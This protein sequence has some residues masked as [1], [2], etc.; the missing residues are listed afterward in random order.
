MK[1]Q[2]YSGR[3]NPGSLVK[4]L[5]RVGAK[6]LLY[7][8]TVI[9]ET[10]AY[11]GI[12]VPQNVPIIAQAGSAGTGI[13]KND[14]HDGRTGDRIRVKKVDFHLN[15]TCAN[16]PDT[17][18]A[19]KAFRLILL[20]DRNHNGGPNPP[21]QTDVFNFNASQEWLWPN[22]GNRHRFKQLKTLTFSVTNPYDS[23]G[24]G[25]LASA[26]KTLEM[27]CEMDLPIDYKYDS[28]DGDMENITDNNLYLWIQPI[29]PDSP[30]ALSTWYLQGSCRFYYTS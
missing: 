11:Y 17:A 3:Q 13:L 22:M 25:A 14:N 27:S 24:T 28:T 1:R 16:G 9:N 15:M 6:T 20:L 5:P 23:S 19:T 12:G 4:D 26:N 30:A 8:D 10:A 7:A 2:R 21:A 29:G 18:P